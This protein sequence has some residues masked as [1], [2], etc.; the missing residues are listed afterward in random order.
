MFYQWRK[1]A[2]LIYQ[3]SDAILMFWLLFWYNDRNKLPAVVLSSQIV[4]HMLQ[5]TN[6]I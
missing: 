6:L 3:Q 5:M 4:K 1:P 2:V